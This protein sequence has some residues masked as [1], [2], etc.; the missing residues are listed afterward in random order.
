MEQAQLDAHLADIAGELV[1][2]LCGALEASQTYPRVR[3]W[4]NAVRQCEA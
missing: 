2:H 1:D 4:R 3:A